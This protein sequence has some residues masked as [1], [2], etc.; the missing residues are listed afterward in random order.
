MFLDHDQKA[1]GIRGGH[2]LTSRFDVSLV[3]TQLQDFDAVAETQV[4]IEPTHFSQSAG[5][6]VFYDDKNFAYLRLYRSESLAR[7]RW[8]S[9]WSRTGPSGSCSVT[10]PRPIP[11]RSSCSCACTTD[12]CS[13]AGVP[14]GEENF[15][16]IGPAIDASYLSDETTRGFTGTMVGIACV[17]SYRRELVA[18]FGYFDLQHGISHLD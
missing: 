18:Q 14:P 4:R 1:L 11:T 8:A 15:H 16:D 3:A 7:T 5:L 10:G 12:A 2:A 13:S 17:D 9:C 6:V